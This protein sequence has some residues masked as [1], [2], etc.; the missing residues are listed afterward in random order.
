MPNWCMCAHLCVPLLIWLIIQS[1]FFVRQARHLNLFHPGHSNRLLSL[2]YLAPITGLSFVT[3]V[4]GLYVLLSSSHLFQVP[5]LYLHLLVWVGPDSAMACWGS[6]FLL[7][8]WGVLLCPSLLCLIHLLVVFAVCPAG[9]IVCH[10]DWHYGKI[11]CLSC[12]CHQMPVCHE[13]CLVSQIMF[14]CIN[15]WTQIPLYPGGSLPML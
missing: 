8:A 3:I 15:K 11:S 1:S 12:W 5:P 2:T 7:F 10:T 6:L 13:P 4:G 9:S 14:Y